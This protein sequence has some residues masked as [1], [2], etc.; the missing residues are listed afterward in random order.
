MSADK[1]HA[2]EVVTDA[3]L[4][5]RLLTAQFPHWA[6]LPIEPVRSAGTDNAIYR[7]GDDMAVRLPRIQW[8]IGQV[9]KE[10]QWLPKLAPHLPL[11]IPVPL[12]KGIPAE[13]YPWEWGVYR[14]LEG[15]NAT[16][17]RIADPHRA[18]ID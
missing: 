17:D 13:G 11:A 16:L 1:M 12:A 2:D 18:A 6:N 10:W 3:S 8:A 14:W 4:V 7:L 15:E 5:S 9:D